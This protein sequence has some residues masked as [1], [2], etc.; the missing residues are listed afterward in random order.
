VLSSAFSP[1]GTR[2]VTGGVDRTAR[3]WD[4]ESGQLLEI[5]RGPRDYVNGVAYGPGD[6]IAAASYDG[7]GRIFHCDLCVPFDELLEIAERRASALTPAEEAQY[8]GQD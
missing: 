5:L 6:R 7:D 4:A 3:V 1:D 8:L 2:V